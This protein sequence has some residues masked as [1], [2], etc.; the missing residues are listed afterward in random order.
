[1][2]FFFFSLIYFLPLT[3][4]FLGIVFFSFVYMGM[5]IRQVT[6]RGND[7][8]RTRAP[9]GILAISISILILLLSSYLYWKYVWIWG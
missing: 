1:M 4:V 2:F 9:N 5:G 6:Y 7:A 3:I 8:E